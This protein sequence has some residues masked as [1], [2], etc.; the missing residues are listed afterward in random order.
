M[1]IIEAIIDDTKRQV[2]EETITEVRKERK[3]TI[4]NLQNEGFSNEKIATILGIS[5]EEILRLLNKK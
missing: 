1:G 4:Q 2:R 3:T 5:I